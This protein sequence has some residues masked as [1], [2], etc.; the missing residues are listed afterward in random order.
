MQISEITFLLVP[1]MLSSAFTFLL[2]TA[3]IPA[4]TARGFVGKDKNK[5]GEPLVP[6][7]GG[8]ALL[9]GV[10]VGLLTTIFLVT[11]TN[12]RGLK[13]LRMLYV[14]D[15]KLKAAAVEELKRELPKLVVT[16]FTEE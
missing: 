16:Q 12:L 9:G 15:L 1:M 5:P 11:F 10:L 8:L 2:L 4:A 14:T 3:L 6:E 7:I 13:N